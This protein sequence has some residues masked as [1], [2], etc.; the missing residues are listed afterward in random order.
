MTSSLIQPKILFRV[1]S[2]NE[3][4]LGHIK[5]CAALAS[6]LQ[7]IDVS[8]IF[9]CNSG[10]NEISTILNPLGVEVIELEDR[11]NE[12]QDLPSI[13]MFLKARN[14]DTFIIDSYA[15]DKSYL[16]AIRN[17]GCQ[18]AYFE[19]Y[20]FPDWPV[21]IIINGLIGSEKLNYS[22]KK[23]FLGTRH[24]ILEKQYWDLIN[25]HA[26]ALNADEILITCGGI[27][28]Y[29]LMPKCLDQIAEINRALKVHCVIG[30]YFENEK[31]IKMAVARNPH[32]IKLHRQPKSLSHLIKQCNIA[33]SAGGMTL[34]ELA[35][36]GVPSIGI[37]L[38]ENQRMNVERL[39]EAGVIIPLR[40][41][42]EFGF[43]E[44]LGEAI[45]EL[46][47]NF[48]KQKKLQ[49]AGRTLIDGQGARRVAKALI[50][51]A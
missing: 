5:R 30:P 4:G 27:D 23:V 22:N 45:R 16:K 3:V 42:D 37:I 40:Y 12:N 31:K 7:E 1:D 2:Y 46:V 6:A 15:I 20:G 28:H 24:L 36:H 9:V 39:G 26:P 18:V 48:E 49:Q 14:I 8:S 10:E 47:G 29:D 11:V 34:Y 50:D 19:D 51:L 21:D 17:V 38:W 43:E 32:R 35:A 25:N 44:I 13:L 41:V 33:I